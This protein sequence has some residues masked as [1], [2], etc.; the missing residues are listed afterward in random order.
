MKKRHIF[1][2]A[3]V[4]IISLAFFGNLL[5]ILLSSHIDFTLNIWH[6]LLGIITYSILHIIKMLRYY[7]IL[8]ENH[9]N[10]Y[11]F[12]KLYI[13]FSLVNILIPKKIG[14]IY[15]LYA[16]GE[17]I[18]N[19]RIAL[20]SIITQI[21]FDLISIVLILIINLLV[22]KSVNILILILFSFTIV[23]ASLTYIIFPATYRY[24]NTFFISKRD[25]RRDIYALDLLSQTNDLY[26]YQRDILKGK[27]GM[28]L[29]ISLIIWLLEYFVSFFI[30]KNIGMDYTLDT[31]SKYIANILLL[32]T[33]HVNILSAMYIVIGSI[34]FAIFLLGI[35]TFKRWGR[36]KNWNSKYYLYMMI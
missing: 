2:N 28:I 31:F 29:I 17:K 32:E 33:N 21:Y 24:L 35:V 16:I 7:L 14:E 9:I 25:K 20:L 15:K 34:L 22:F 36:A 23:L 5:S 19:Y 30:A 4:A 10:T 13:K 18:D 26:K 11:D 12:I 6:I 1:I 27:G 8:S 3:I